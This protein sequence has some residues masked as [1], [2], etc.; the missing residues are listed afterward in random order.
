[1]ITGNYC[2]YNNINNNYYEETTSR[3][4]KYIIQGGIGTVPLVDLLVVYLKNYANN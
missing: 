3:L 2:N 1:M 4:C